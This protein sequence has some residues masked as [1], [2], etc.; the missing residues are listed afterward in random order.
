MHST[1]SHASY[2]HV[3]LTPGYDH[4]GTAA[5]MTVQAATGAVEGEVGKEA[6]GI[7]CCMPAYPLCLHFGTI[8]QSA[9]AHISTCRACNSVTHA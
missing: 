2:I 8:A 9:C 3:L 1:P 4:T 6:Y 7:R 5:Q